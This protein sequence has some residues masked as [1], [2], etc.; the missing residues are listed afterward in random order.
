MFTE[1]E[2]DILTLLG[3]T[4]FADKRVFAREIESFIESASELDLG[5]GRS[6]RVNNDTLLLWFEANRQELK[7]LHTRT[8][9]EPW[10]T[11]LID[12]LA[13]YPH[14]ERLLSIIYDI[15][16]SDG[17]IHVSETALMVLCARRWGLDL[18]A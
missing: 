4:I 2:D 18:A 7:T 8:D 13:G 10:I 14:K 11:A 3:I 1:T 15:S 9:F 17:E 16:R 6:E 12:R 5:T